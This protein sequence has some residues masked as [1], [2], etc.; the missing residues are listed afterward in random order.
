M[1]FP[2]WGLIAHL[3]LALPRPSDIVSASALVRGGMA[4]VVLQPMVLALGTRSTSLTF[5][6]LFR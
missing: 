6:N 3:Q 1:G 5:A 2:P 4:V